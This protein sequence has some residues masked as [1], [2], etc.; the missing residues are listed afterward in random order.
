MTA[1][2]ARRAL[3]VEAAAALYPPERFQI[4]KMEGL[5]GSVENYYHFILG[6]VAPVLMRPATPSGEQSFLAKSCAV[7]DEKFL[8]LGVEDVT[9]L[10]RN[11]WQQLEKLGGHQVFTLAGLDRKFGLKDAT[12]AYLG[13]QIAA[14]RAEIFRRLR[15]PDLPGRP[16]VLFVNRG[17]PLDHYLSKHAEAKLSANVRRSIPNMNEIV[18]AAAA[19]G[20]S[21]E[22]VY[23]ESATL[24]A[25]VSLFSTARIVVA[26]HGAALVNMLWMRPGSLVVEIQPPVQQHVVFRKIAKYCGHRYLSVPQQAVHAPVDPE[27]VVSMLRV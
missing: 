2:S 14:L 26:Q 3:T 25:Q 18:A 16:G 15:I 20:L 6:F 24:R 17:A 13:Q 5:G 9:L 27:A 10:P 22:L 8:E 12:P 19:A 21:P 7:L 11:V 1:A 23:L 4:L